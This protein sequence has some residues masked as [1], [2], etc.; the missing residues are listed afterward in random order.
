[1]AKSSDDK[2]GTEGTLSVIIIP[3]GMLY[4][5]WLTRWQRVA[6]TKLVLMEL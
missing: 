4:E 6:M 1:M 3:C 2:I 5:N